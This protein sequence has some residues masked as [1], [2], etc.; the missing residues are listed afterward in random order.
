VHIALCQINPRI[1]DVAGNTAQILEQICALRDDHDLIVFPEFALPGYPPTDQVFRDDFLSEVAAAN[2]RVVDATREGK[3]TVAWGTMIRANVH[4]QAR[5]SNGVLVARDGQY[6]AEGR[7]S[8]LPTYGVYDELRFF[9]PNNGE[10]CLFEVDGTR[11]GVTICEDFWRVDDPADFRCYG[12]DLGEEL[13]KAGAQILLNLSASPYHRSKVSER[14]DIVRGVSVK[15]GLPMLYVNLVGGNDD[16]IFDGR[17]LAWD[18]QG[19]EVARAKAYA[20]DTLKLEWTEGALHAAEEVSPADLVDASFEDV[21]EALALGLRDFCH[22]CGIAKVVIGLSG[23][24]DSAVTA[25]LACYALGA[26]N[27]TGVAMPSRISSA[28]SHEDAKVMAEALGLDFKTIAIGDTLDS[29]CG[30]LEDSTGVAPE[31][32]E[33]ENLQPRIRGTLL[34]ALAN[35]K[36]ALVLATGN[37]AEMAVGYCTMYGDMVGGLAVLGDLLKLEV[38]EVGRAL[39]RL[40]GSQMIPERVY[41]KEPTAELRP[42]Q[43]DEDSLPPYDKLDLFIENYLRHKMAPGQAAPEG[44][45]GVRWAKVIESMDFKRFQA[46]PVLRVSNFA[47]QRERQTMVAKG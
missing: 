9:A 2:Q 41:T 18:D 19:N 16:I 25:S 30:A 43:K 40:W 42:E 12:T 31:G 17:S 10:L 36:R 35:R 28:S 8:H 7:K 5:P 14:Q 23:G 46:P 26:E 44:L 22:K 34:M 3:A 37:K 24:I 29:F 15:T 39:D 33:H 38:Y 27:V 13:K 1:A 21:S 6:V 47:F 11:I 45:D 32:L 20:P 4:C